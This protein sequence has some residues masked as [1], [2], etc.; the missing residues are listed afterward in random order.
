MTKIIFITTLLSV[1]LTQAA[2]IS[3]D[4]NGVADFNSIQAAIDF[5][6]DGD[7]IIVQQGIYDEINF[8]GKNVTVTSTNPADPNVVKQTIIDWEEEILNLYPAVRFL[9][10]ETDDCTLSGFNIKGPIY[11]YDYR[12]TTDHTHATIK[13]CLLEGI[14][15]GWGEIIRGHD[16]IISNCIFADPVQTAIS[17]IHFPLPINRCHGLFTNCTFINA[18]IEIGQNSV[19]VQNCIFKESG[20]LLDGEAELN[21]RYSNLAE[22]MDS[23]IANDPNSVNYG[24]GNINAD[25]CFVRQGYWDGNPI[26]GQDPG[27]YHP[28]DY[29]LQ[30]SA[31]RWDA[32]QNQWVT[33]SN[34]SY[35]IDAGNPGCSLGSEPM[36]NGNR[37]NMGAYGGTATASKSPE[38]WR[39]IADL[40]NDWVMDE[41]DLR[42]FCDYWLADSFEPP[43]DLNRDGKVG[44]KD[45]AVFAMYYMSPD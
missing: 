9:G 4:D 28:G 14:V 18:S 7:I 13:H 31:G 26:P 10:T 1:T 27:Q 3:V 2:I 8:L 35:C 43:S 6:D 29:H 22:G 25:P 30:S 16:G 21:I 39:N 24:P 41:S 11:G 23:I 20:I 33:D 45:Y 5:A 40:N 17:I 42:I 36:P 34:T 12:I 32:N 19:T 44:F 15:S 37:I 38:N